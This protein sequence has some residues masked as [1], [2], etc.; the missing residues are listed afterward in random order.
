MKFVSSPVAGCGTV[1]G[2][3]R[4]LEKVVK[5]LVVA[6]KNFNPQPLHKLERF[7]QHLI[8]SVAFQ[9]HGALMSVT[10]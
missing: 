7:S 3:S 5:S 8:C 9:S 1:L 4:H 6:A 10:A 2:N